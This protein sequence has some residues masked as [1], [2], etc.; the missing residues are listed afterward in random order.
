MTYE[1]TRR[2]V[3]LA[4]GAAGAVAFVAACGG[5]GDDNGSAPTSSPTGEETAGRRTA[6]QEL[7]STDEIPVGGGK[8]FK[9]EEVVVTQPEQ[10]RFKAF[11]AICTHQRCTVASVA[12]GTINCVCHGSRFRIADGSVAHGPATRPLPAEKIT[13]EGNSVRLT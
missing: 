12:D 9:D 11:S 3:L 2:A 8:I 7:A 13:V 10:G 1:T 4:T 5:G 6:G